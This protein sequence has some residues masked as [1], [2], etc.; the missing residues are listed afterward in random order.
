[1]NRQGASRQAGTRLSFQP[2]KR[3]PPEPHERVLAHPDN[4]PSRG[5][6]GT[7]RTGLRRRPCPIDR[8]ASSSMHDPPPPTGNSSGLTDA[9]GPIPLREGTGTPTKHVL[10]SRPPGLLGANSDLG[11]PP[12]SSCAIWAGAAS[13]PAREA[14]LQR[15]ISPGLRPFL[16][17]QISH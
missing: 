4:D 9:L 12:F 13:G 16:A 7:G 1:M 14:G 3:F 17:R 5:I 10:P 15:L 6:C 11:G 2:L 8:G